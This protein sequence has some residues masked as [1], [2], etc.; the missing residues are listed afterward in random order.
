[1]VGSHI[2][3]DFA[4]VYVLTDEGANWLSLVQRDEGGWTEVA[5]GDSGLM[6]VNTVDDADEDIDRGVVACAIPVDAP[7]DYLVHYA[8]STATIRAAEPYVVA[9]LLGVVADDRLR[10]TRF[11]G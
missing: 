11:G 10:V 5:G 9:V 4:A 2:N 6:W 3:G 1:V 7:G 8:D